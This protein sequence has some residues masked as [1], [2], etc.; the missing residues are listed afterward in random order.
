MLL[1]KY[2]DHPAGCPI[3]YLSEGLH[4]AVVVALRVE[5]NISRYSR[6]PKVLDRDPLPLV[7]QIQD[8]KIMFDADQTERVIGAFRLGQ[9][10]S[11]VFARL[12]L[13][14]DTVDTPRVVPNGYGNASLLGAM[15]FRSAAELRCLDPGRL[16]SVGDL[17]S[18]LPAREAGDVAQTANDPL[19]LRIVLIL[20]GVSPMLGSVWNA[21]ELSA[22]LDSGYKQTETALDKGCAD[23][24]ADLRHLAAIIRQARGY[25]P[26]LVGV[27]ASLLCSHASCLHGCR[28]HIGVGSVKMDHA[29]VEVH[30]DSCH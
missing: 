12:Q 22:Y 20:S 17:P 30:P 3:L 18:R 4:E 27:L 6:Y 10:Q 2:F 9:H 24:G 25:A 1:R 21:G 8:F 26:D 19:P 13:P 11:P 14:D 28:G 15:I 23:E 16:A 29:H 5:W 7:F